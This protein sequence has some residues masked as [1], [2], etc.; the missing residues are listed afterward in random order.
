MP[1]QKT[2]VIER[3]GKIDM[4]KRRRSVIVVLLIWGMLAT[5]LCTAPAV[6]ALAAPRQ[7]VTD[8]YHK[9]C[10]SPEDGGGCYGQPRYHEC[11]GDADTGGACYEDTPHVHVEVCYLKDQECIFY[12]TGG[13]VIGHKTDQCPAHGFVEFDIAEGTSRHTSCGKGEVASTFIYCPTC[14]LPSMEIH[15][16]DVVTCGLEEGKYYKNCGKE[17][18][19]VL[20]GYELNCGLEGAC[21]RLIVTNESEEEAEK[22]LL[23]VQVE[24]LSGGKLILSS[25]PYTWYDADGNILGNGEYLEV[26]K[27]GNYQ[28]EVH[29][30][31]Q[32]VEEE[33][34]RSTISVDTIGGNREPA[35]EAS[36][37]PEASTSP[38]A[39][40]SPEASASPRGSASPE[41][42][43]E[44]ES[45]ATP[46]AEPDS[47]QEDG[48]ESVP[49]AAP[50]VSPSTKPLEIRSEENHGG[51]LLKAPYEF[52]GRQVSSSDSKVQP[53]IAPTVSPT[54]KTRETLMRQEQEVTAPKAMEDIVIEVKPVT[55]RRSFWKRPVV[56]LIS[57]TLG[58]LLLFAGI[59]LLL[60]YLRRSVRL[61]NDNGEG[62]W[63]YLGRLL[64]HK[65]EEGYVVT[66][67]E[68]LIE[69]AYTNRY[70]IRPGLFLLGRSEE[71]LL[72]YGEERRAAVPLSREMI[73]ML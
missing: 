15:E 11:Q 36:S 55:D 13:T 60:F 53:T 25:E 23:H 10:G 17:D 49:S 47:Q 7:V 16:Y 45:E 71:E 43:G 46:S 61:Y 22:A 31:N 18:E 56:R 62:K 27:N 12:N 41:T 1:R 26:D 35:P 48:A 29:L 42:A 14:G 69:K 64:V 57:I 44:Q 63:L 32:D 8:I 37:S 39:S 3:K 19:K 38:E 65:E 24:D 40:S 33:G 68:K 58:S 2:R 51:D 30:E 20:E 6:T 21:G 66:I 50:T 67:P 52:S 9:H 73:V 59:F 28:V 54:G 34:L 72:V 5:V 4:D 70:E